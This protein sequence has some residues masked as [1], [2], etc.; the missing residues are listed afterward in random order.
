MCAIFSTSKSLAV[1]AALAL[2]ERWTGDSRQAEAVAPRS[3][4]GKP[5]FDVRASRRGEVRPRDGQRVR[6]FARIR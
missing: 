2:P 1:F 3:I 5:A 4:V 6:A